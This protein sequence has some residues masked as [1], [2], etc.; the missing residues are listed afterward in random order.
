[1]PITL[2]VPSGSRRHRTGRG[3]PRV[4]LV[5]PDVLESSCRT[6]QALERYQGMTLSQALDAHAK[7]L[8]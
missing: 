1:M 4:A 7:T 5:I 6:R 2:G 3:G 8:N